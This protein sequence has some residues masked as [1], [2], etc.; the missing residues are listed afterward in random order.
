[1]KKNPGKLRR[2]LILLGLVM[3]CGLSVW[4]Q[5]KNITGLVTD[6]YGEA[7]P[8]CSVV[9]KGTT[10]GT[11]TGI[12]GKYSIKVSDA[13]AVVVYSF[14]G[15]RSQDVIIGN[16]TTINIILEDEMI[17][18]DEV[19]VIGYGTQKKANLTGAVASMKIDESVNQ[20]VTN[21]SQLLQGRMSGVQLTQASGQPGKDGATINIRGIG[22]NGN[23]NPMVIVD[24]IERSLGD[25]AP[26]DIE[27]ISV[28]KD[29]ASAAIYG[30]R[31][32]N[33][34]ILVTTKTGQSGEMKI[35][36]NSYYGWQEA[37]VLPDI[38]G[39]VE[40][41]DMINIATGTERY[42]PEMI[43]K[44][45]DGS[46]RDR[47]AQTNWGDELFRVAPLQNH[48]LSFSG[49]NEKSNYFLSMNYMDQE[50]IML[51]TNS[52]RYNL[53]GKFDTQIK[54]WLKV[55]LNMDGSI[56]NTEE[57]VADLTGDN[58]LIN[59]M[60]FD[61]PVAPVKYLADPNSPVYGEWGAADGSP[62]SY[63]VKNAVFKS[64]LGENLE[65]QQRF[66]T[67]VYALFNL[68]EGLTFETSL[69]YKYNNQLA[70]KYNPA[71]ETY[72]ADGNVEIQKEESRLMNLNILKTTVLN[73]NILKYNKVVDKHNFNVLLGHSTQAYRMD[74]F[75]SVKEGFVNNEVH[76]L[77]GGSTMISIDGRAN[78]LN[79]QSFFGRVA[80]NYND[81]YL[82]EANVR[83]DGSS[84]FPTDSKYGTF[85]SFSAAW[86]ISEESFAESL[87]DIFSNIKLRGSWGMLGNQEIGEYYP[88]ASTWGLGENY[89]NPDGSVAGGSAITELK[90]SKLKWETTESYNV[91]VDMTVMNKLNV[92]ADYFVKKT[93]DVLL[94]LPLPNSIGIAAAPF[95]NAG[96]AL[97]RGWELAADYRNRAGAFTYHA[98]FNI[99]K[100]HNEW[101]DLQGQEFYPN[102]R[103]HRE[104][105][106][107]FSYFG[108][109]SDGIF[110]DE[111]EVTNHAV[112]TNKTAPGDL[113]IKDQL[114]VDTN[115]DGIPDEADGIINE[116][117]RVI[118]G[119]PIPEFTYGFNGGFEVKGI[120]FSFLFQ[121]VQNVD[122]YTGGTGNHSGRSDRKN[123]ITDWTDYW[124]PENT[125]ASHP[126]LGGEPLNDQTSSFY[127]W[128]ASYLRLK[129]IEIGYSLPGKWTSQIHVDKLRVYVGAQNLLTFSDFKHWDPERAI[130]NTSNQAY[131]LTKTVSVGVNVRF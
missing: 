39:A 108:Y 46:D 70:S 76:E 41:A 11:I 23:S 60:F 19:V 99:T 36:F 122:R 61:S 68:M 24:G 85:P 51:N 9:E 72:D 128:D 6:K 86:R 73:E 62:D 90:N 13:T 97:N 98:G 130:G 32:A 33:G 10:N 64:Y 82:L 58:G 12:N 120:D 81:R 43:Q 106:A 3:F 20:P 27:S 107:M 7:I 77:D 16:Q 87:T 100:I 4:A 103:V 28:L 67:R 125:D 17:G 8:G 29:A 30:A 105:E 111:D 18:V 112:Q 35:N 34:V 5:E 89:L 69:G 92:T 117:D 83:R 14:I 118:I 127:I 2:I 101:T 22:T 48:Y 115:G 121:G 104:G 65:D 126:R 114:T 42:T 113:K 119:N 53:R 123:W 21:T 15:M 25:I 93:R 84:R 38:V 47:F 102:Q 26:S 1:M 49:G 124:T 91:G 66:N 131:P 52:K 44:I 50:G 55:G 116:D 71:F 75:Q 110:Q 79:L 54:S 129:N 109:E 57:P 56:R 95:Q 74:H 59:L 80:Y 31:A 45:K 96:E 88:H 40:Y 94:R 37:T 63:S 78:E